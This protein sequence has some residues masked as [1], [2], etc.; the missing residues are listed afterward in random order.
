LANLP[1]ASYLGN[2]NLKA[3]GVNVEFTKEQIKEYVKC[4]ED[5]LYF[6][7]NYVKIVHL[8]RG[9]VPFDLYDFQEDIVNK[10]HDNRF[11]IAKL[12]R[13]SG[14]STTVIAYLLHYVLFNPSMNV[15]I[16]ANK[17]ATAR[18]LLS[19]LKLAYEHLPIWL[20]QGV[21]SWNKGS[22]ELENGSRI[23]AS[24]TSSSAVRG[25]S[26]NMIFLDEF[27]YVPHNVAEDFFSSVYPTI[28]SGQSTKVLLI[29]TPKGL[30][31]FY[32]FWIDAVE[33]RNDYLPI[34]VHW[35]QVPGRDEKWKIQTI[36]NTSEDQ[37]KVEF[38]CD[39]IGSTATLITSTKLKSMPYKEPILKNAEGLKMYDKPTEGHTYAMCV[40]TSRGQ[41]IDYSAFIVIDI[42]ELPYKVVATYKNNEISPMVYPTV[43]YRLGKQY[44]DAHLLIEVNDIGAQV[45]DILHAEMEYEHILVTSVRGRKGQTMDGG[46]GSSQTQYGVRTTTAVKRL[47]CSIL[48]SLIEEDK[49]L[50]DDFDTI[51]ELVSFVAHK[52]SFAADVGHHD[53]LVIC[54]VLFG[55]LTTQSYFKDLTDLDLRRDLYHDK[56]QRLE[57]EM[58]P[59]GFIDDGISSQ[60]YEID[61][62]GQQWS[63]VD[64]DE[65]EP[66]TPFLRL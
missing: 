36:K 21:E 30:N 65:E 16:L 53:D 27:A 47:G 59:F 23:L 64:F 4:S 19:R 9:L 52:D 34:E 40:D 55:W 24:A 49:L 1:T 15:A 20:Q 13:Q 42:T 37:F 54:L 60:K 63:V 45:A 17:L 8:D 18:E 50:I 32:K 26:F 58:T 35:N 38:E 62:K 46:F 39:F 57:D 61:S 56:I 7:K 41:G 28:T 6:I 29:S 44:N 11:I 48:K 14:K 3:S 12:P 33:G 51:S 5:P 66:P 25:G 22:I 2:H 10:I 31:M 43:I